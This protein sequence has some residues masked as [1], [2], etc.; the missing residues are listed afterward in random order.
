MTL[1][2]RARVWLGLAI[3]LAGLLPGGTRAAYGADLSRYVSSDFCGALVIH[4]ERI[5]KSELAVALKSGLS[6][7]MTAADPVAAALAAMGKQ[8]K[9]DLP[10]G[11]DVAKLA[12]LLDGKIVTRIVILIEPTPTADPKVSPGIIIQFGNDIDGEAILAA[13]STDWKS[14]ETHGIQYKTVK[15]DPGKP[16][17]AAYVPDARTLIA[18]LEST[19]VKMLAKDQGSQPLLKQLQNTKIDNDIILEYLAEPIWAAAAKGTSTE[20]ALSDLGGPNAA[21]MAKD[22]KSMSIKLNFSGKT[23][24]HAEV[25]TDKPE[26]AAQYAALAQM[27]IGIVKPQF[28]DMKKQPPPFLPPPAVPVISKLGDEVFDGLT[29]KNDGPQ[30]VVDLPMPAS[31]PDALKLAAQLAGAMA[32]PMPPKEGPTH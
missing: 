6:K 20:K 12:K 16:D 14:A 17:F 15:T 2:R 30:L 7:E 19:V 32:A 8:P 25:V 1:Q 23:L 28:Q 26:V 24:L 29:V 5:N 9:K 10:P 11:M 22:L 31:L 18:G 13:F 21:K 3:A 27:G 4:P